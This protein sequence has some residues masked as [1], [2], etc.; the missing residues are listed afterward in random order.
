[1]LQNEIHLKN[2]LK[3]LNANKICHISIDDAYIP[4]SAYSEN[5]MK[6]PHRLFGLVLKPVVIIAS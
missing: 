1:M 3:I 5:R 4:I 2:I 6:P